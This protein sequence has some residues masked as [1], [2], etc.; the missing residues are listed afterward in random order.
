MRFTYIND[1]N[2]F[3]ARFERNWLP[4]FGVWVDATE[5]AVHAFGKRI[6]NFRR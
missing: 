4:V 1:E 2:H 6:V 3:I 5:V